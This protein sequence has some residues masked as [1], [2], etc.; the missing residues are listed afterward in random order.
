MKRKYWEIYYKKKKKLFKPSNFSKFINKKKIINKK[1]N[2][3]EMGCGDGRD[4]FYFSKT[5]QNIVA[6]DSSLEI[7]RKNN[8][9]KI[10]NNIKNIKFLCVNVA[11]KNQF[12]LLVKEKKFNIV[13]ARFFLHAINEK[14]EKNLFK[15]FDLL[16]KKIVYFFEFRTSKDD[17]INH[18]KKISKYERMTSHYRRFI[19]TNDFIKKIKKMNFK[20][21]YFNERK[22]LSK[23][24]NEDPHLCRV[25]FKKKS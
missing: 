11:I 22:G 24:K 4:S 16:S 3:L 19:N 15:N 13:Y 7:I 2:I 21:L 14:S 17:L 5:A 10:N 20:I 12:K 6:V 9:Y 23:F 8:I 18:G 1:S 25:I